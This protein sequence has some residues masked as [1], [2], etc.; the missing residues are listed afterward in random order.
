M[1]FLD[2]RLVL[3]L[4]VPKQLSVSSYIAAA[5]SPSEAHRIAAGLSKCAASFLCAVPMV[6][7]FIINEG[8]FTRSLQRHN[9]IAPVLTP[10]T[11]NCGARGV[12]VLGAS[13]WV[14]L[15]NCACLGENI[16]PH[17]AVWGALAHAIYQCGAASVVP[18]TEVPL[19]VPGGHW[20]ADTI[21][22]DD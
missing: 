19:D 11:H 10:Y 3:P 7:S 9:G 16:H 14:H 1:S 18:H 15:N 2:I 22:M 8:T 6:K 21:F 5:S 13:D 12:L 4:D 17:N 20:K